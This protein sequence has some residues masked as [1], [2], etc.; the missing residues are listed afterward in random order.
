[1]DERIST[2]RVAQSEF[3]CTECGRDAYIGYTAGKTGD[4]DGKVKPGERL[5][6]SCFTKRG[7]ANF[8]A[9]LRAAQV[10][11]WRLI[12]SRIGPG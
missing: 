5:C 11:R 6:T 10:R 1:M 2:G 3:P 4:W 7:G 9:R 12:V 8:F